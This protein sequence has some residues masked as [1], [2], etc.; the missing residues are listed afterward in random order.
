L[1]LFVDLN[2]SLFHQVTASWFT[3]HQFFEVQITARISPAST[4]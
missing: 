4:V 2:I 1:G 3:Q